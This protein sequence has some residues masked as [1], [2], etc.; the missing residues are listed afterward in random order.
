[1][2]GWLWVR[3]GLGRRR[4]PKRQPRLR[5]SFVRHVAGGVGGGMYRRGGGRYSRAGPW[6]WVVWERQGR[7]G[8]IRSGRRGS[9]ARCFGSAR[10]G[11]RGRV[12]CWRESSRLGSAG[13]V[14]G[15][16]RRRRA[17]RGRGTTW[18]RVSGL[19]SG[20]SIA[21]AR[22]AGRAGCIASR[23]CPRC[24]DAASILAVASSSWVHEPARIAMVG[25]Q[26]ASRLAVQASVS[27]RR[28]T[29]HQLRHLQVLACGGAAGQALSLGCGWA[30][31]WSSSGL[32]P[33]G[34][35]QFYPIFLRQDHNLGQPVPLNTATP[36]SASNQE[37][38]LRRIYQ[39]P[40]S[41]PGT[42]RASRLGPNVVAPLTLWQKGCR[43]IG[44]ADK[45]YGIGI[46]Q[47]PIHCPG[48]TSIPLSLDTLIAT[49]TS[50]CAVQPGRIPA[51]M[52][53]LL[54][55]ETIVE[56][57][58]LAPPGTNSLLEIWTIN[59][60]SAMPEFHP[61]W[62]T[63]HGRREAGRQKTR[64]GPDCQVADMRPGP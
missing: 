39:A 52:S 4:S 25:R 50:L 12:R 54:P 9:R 11:W 7:R 27:A 53:R 32:C 58:L 3:P 57:K 47:C 43:R 22:G 30:Q 1:M 35:A 13:V 44:G 59:L 37:H 24:W 60:P 55:V 20:V 14:G 61:G 10:L 15:G 31:A 48:R 64:N 45:A 2:G 62:P 28:Q 8:R 46:F 63:Y 34:V 29:F 26:L 19:P 56:A 49:I 16:R 23:H 42:N 33:S 51:P 5:L 38:L 41:L 21:S 6:L 40:T 17:R 18:K 36:S